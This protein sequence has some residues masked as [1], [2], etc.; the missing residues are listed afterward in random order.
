MSTVRPVEATGLK[1]IMHWCRSLVGGGVVRL[2]NLVE[3]IGEFSNQSI[4][5]GNLSSHSEVWLTVDCHPDND[6][7]TAW[8]LHMSHA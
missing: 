1:I 6:R 3:Q 2:G 7:R 8:F 5:H 4:L